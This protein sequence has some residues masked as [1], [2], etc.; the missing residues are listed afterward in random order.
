[1]IVDSH[2]HIGGPP[3]EAEPEM[4][5]SLMEKGNIDKAIIFRYFVDKPTLISNKYISD[6][7]TNFPKHYVGFAWINPNE[8][9]AV[10]ELRTAITEWRLEG[11]KMHLEMHPASIALLRPIFKEAQ[12]LSIPICIHMG[13][14]FKTIKSLSQEFNVDVIIAHLGTGVYRLEI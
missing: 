4:F 9:T 5:T 11:V 14:D 8:K 3:Q 2:V 7:V 1:L 12:E 13:E 6:V 10:T